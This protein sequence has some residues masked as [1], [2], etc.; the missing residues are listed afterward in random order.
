[1]MSTLVSPMPPT[2]TEVPTRT[3]PHCGF[4]ERSERERCSRCGKSVLVRAPRL[5]G[6]RRTQV[7]WGSVAVGV[8]AV[9]AIALVLN[10]VVSNRNERE[11]KASA[12]AIAAE[13]VRLE[14]LQAPHRGSATQLAPPAGASDLDRLN[15]RAA[16]VRAAE[17]S[18]TRDAQARDRRGELEGP[19]SRH[20]VRPAAEGQGRRPRRPHPQQGDRPLRLRRG[21][22]L[23]HRRGRAVGRAPGLPLRRRP[24][25]QEVH[26]RLVSQ[27]ARPGRARRRAG[28]RAPGPRVP[29]GQGPRA[30]HGLRRRAGQLGPARASRRR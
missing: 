18:I 6:R 30:G 22:D 27:H 11:R 16:L 23:G 15:A 8:L 21:Q 24:G 5:R 2:M 19:I 13:R 12:K 7:I 9:A 10:A 26:L 29:G 4:E 3:C 1:M 25:L 17:A 28:L 20:R 14:R